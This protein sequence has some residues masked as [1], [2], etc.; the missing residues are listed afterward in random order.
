M[1]AARYV[2]RQLTS[3]QREE[4]LAWRVARLRPWHSPPHQTKAGRFCFHISAACFEHAHYIGFSKDRMDL[5]SNALLEGLARAEG[6]VCAWCVLPNHY[7]VLVRTEDLMELMG[8]L[9]RL[10]GKMSFVWNAEENRRGR[11]VF[12]R[13]TD[14]MIRSERHFRA[15]MNYVHHNAVHHGYV[16]LWTEWPWSSSHSYIERVGRDEAERVWRTYPLKGFGAKWD[17]SGI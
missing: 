12:F 6:E 15:T 9:G 10:H 17:P 3:K 16:K 2:W 1:A 8:E 13:A 7:H 11:K 14:R 5:F 4:L